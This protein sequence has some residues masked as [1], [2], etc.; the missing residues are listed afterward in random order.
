MKNLLSANLLRLKKSRLF[1]GTLILSFGFGVWVAVS[2]VLEQMRYGG[3]EDSPAFSRYTTLIGVVI[4][5]FVSMFF[6]TEYSDGTIRNKLVTG[7]SRVSM[8][9]ANLIAASVCGL[10]FSIAYLAS[11]F[12]VGAPFLSSGLFQ[13]LSVQPRVFV[14]TLAGLLVLTLAYSALFL[15]IV[16]NCAHKTTSAVACILAA[17]ALLIAGIYLN[18]RLDAPEYISGYSVDVGGQ[19]VEEEPELNPD[20]LRGTK[21]AAYQFLYDFLPGGQSV[22]YGAA[23]GGNLIGMPVYSLIIFAASTGAGAALFR[24]KDLK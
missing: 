19:F 9:L 2:Q 3:F 1:W 24:R 14:L 16:M 23:Q 10:L 7:Q 13:F 20:Y 22:Q 11:C 18:G 5:V 15:L 21:R 4:A 17:F 12:A 6:G 8:Y